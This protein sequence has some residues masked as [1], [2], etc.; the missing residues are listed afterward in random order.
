MTV[1]DTDTRD[2]LKV[3]AKTQEL[4]NQI[5]KDEII[6]LDL[7]DFALVC[8]GLKSQS[9]G[10]LGERWLCNKLGLTRVTGNKDW[11]AVS[12]TGLRYEIKFSIAGPNRKFNVVQ[13]RP[14]GSLDAYLI[15]G[16]G[17]DNQGYV[18]HL[19]KMEMNDELQLLKA[20]SAHGKLDPR[21]PAQERRFTF[22]EGGDTFKRW[23]MYRLTH[24][25]V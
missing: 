24:S 7:P 25:G 23:E 15:F 11:D 21:N 5:S 20:G 6:S 13:V 19:N 9:Y 14:H 22:T 16:I 12:D 17:Y 18:W 1:L 10:A 3:M 4:V 2:L 8:R